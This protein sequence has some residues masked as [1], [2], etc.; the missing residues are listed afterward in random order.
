M[1]WWTLLLVACA[2]GTVRTPGWDDDTAAPGDTGDTGT[3]VETVEV[4][5]PRELRG[6]WVATVWNINFPSRRDLTVAAQQAELDRLVEATAEA[7]LNALFF[8]VRPEGDAL[9]A[10]PYEP[11]SHVLT[12]T[13]GQ[14]PGYD[15]LAYLIDAAHARHVEVHVWLNPYRA[16]ASSTSYAA[17]HLATQHPDW[18]VT[19]GAYDWMDPG[20]AGVRTRLVDVVTDLATRYAIDGVHFDDYFYPYP[21]GPFPDTATYAAYTSQGG[22]LALA[23]WRRD[24][25]NTAIREVAEALAATDPSVRFGV[26]PFGIYRPGQPEGVTGF[27]QYAGLYADPMKWMDEGWV[28]YLAPQLYWVST[29]TGQPY[30]K[31]IEWWADQTSGGRMIFSGDYLSQLGSSSAWTVDEF[32]TQVAL[33]R[34]QAPN[35]ARGHIFY[36]IAPL[37]TD[38]QG[39]VSVFADELF[40]TPAL[41]PPLHTAVGRVAAPP[42]VHRAGLVATAVH[43]DAV[44]PR[45][46]AVFRDDGG[47]FAPHAL[48]RPDEPVT[49]AP[50]RWALATVAR[51]GILSPAVVLTVD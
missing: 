46:L 22:T 24:N 43:E 41:T 5:W 20:I 36:N 39:I 17:T 29:S 44:A 12:G 51:D 3:Q 13:Q 8:Q 38:R 45:A 33:T 21:D 48:H 47:D 6:V 1:K 31:L 26:A 49:L 19:Y 14:D 9:Y 37:L 16:R 35:G 27:D 10:S 23:D 4:A 25:V 40:P 18:V 2:D 42:T 30:G 15:P 50:G 11:W 7:G 28:D 34:A 32:R